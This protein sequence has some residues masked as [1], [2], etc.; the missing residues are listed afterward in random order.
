MTGT[1]LHDFLQW[2]KINYGISA[3]SLEY[4]VEKCPEPPDEPATLI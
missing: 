1:D 2:H 3:D 4:Y